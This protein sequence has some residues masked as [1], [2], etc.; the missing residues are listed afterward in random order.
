M[1]IA[2]HMGIILDIPSIGCAKSHLYGIYKMP[3]K[4]KGD[5]SYIYPQTKTFG[6]GV[7]DKNTRETVGAVLRTRSQVKP[8]FVSCGYKISLRKAIG[9][10]L[11]L[12]PKYR[13][14]QPLRLAHSIAEEFKTMV[15]DTL[16]I[17]SKGAP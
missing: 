11:E 4:N 9:L 14:P 10:V 3:A 6:V 15:G 5:F 7:Y 12:C 17:G 2:T 1:G 16:P 8:I 13:I